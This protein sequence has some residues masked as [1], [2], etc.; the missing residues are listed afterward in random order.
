MSQGFIVWLFI[1]IPSNESGY[2][3]PKKHK[4]R[5]IGNLH[6]ALG[7]KQETEGEEKSACP[8]N[9]STSKL[10]AESRSLSDYY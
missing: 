9:R 2:K 4:T 6:I 5:E 3:S 1:S 10:S 8:E 7:K